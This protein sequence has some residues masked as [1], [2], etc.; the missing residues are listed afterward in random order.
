VVIRCT[1]IARPK[2]EV[3]VEV[4]AGTE[5]VRTVT[6]GGEALLP[7]VVGVGVE[8][9]ARVEHDRSRRRQQSLVSLVW[10]L[11]KQRSGATVR[12]PRRK[13]N[14]DARRI[15]PTPLAPTALMTV[16]H[17]PPPILMTLV[18]SLKQTTSLLLLVLQ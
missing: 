16:P 13:L 17:H 4:E 15:R 1:P 3:E 14:D 10:P 12:R 5:A 8:V 9:E 6:D 2:V 18:S 7:L 11:M